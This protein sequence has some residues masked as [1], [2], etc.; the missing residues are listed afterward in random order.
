MKIKEKVLSSL[1]HKTFLTYDIHT[2]EILQIPNTC[3]KSKVT[4]IYFVER[5]RD[6]IKIERMFRDRID[7]L[8]S[9]KDINRIEML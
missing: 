9:M 5:Y 2:V 4:C 7:L 6:F 8:S 1:F 3:L